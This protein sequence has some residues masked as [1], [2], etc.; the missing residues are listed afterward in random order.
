MDFTVLAATSV[1]DDLIAKCPPAES[2][3]D[4]FVTMSKATIAMVEKTTGFGTASTLSSQPLNVPQSGSS[5]SGK[6]LAERKPLQRRST[7]QPPL[8][9]FDMDL[10][11]LFSEEEI[12]SRPLAQQFAL[13]T[14]NRR[15]QARSTNADQLPSMPGAPQYQSQHLS[16]SGMSTMQQ[17]QS[18]PALYNTTSGS[19]QP[20]HQHTH[21]QSHTHATY[22]AAYPPQSSTSPILSTTPQ[23]QHQHQ[24]YA[25]LTQTISQTTQSQ[26][27]PDLGGFDFDFLDTFPPPDFTGQG[28]G[29]GGWEDFDMNF[30]TGGMGAVGWGES[31]GQWDGG[32]GGGV[33]MFDGFF[34]GEVGNGGA[35]GNGNGGGGGG[36]FG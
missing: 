26:S 14:A 27:N 16:H 21:S 4:A 7:N 13:H 28:G 25:P 22:N 17:Q 18:P 19:S 29:G 30:A 2:C 36:G 8:P 31:G 34:F 24:Q 23:H 12:A 35:N 32:M 15:A 33:D 11:E 1:L 20:P 6:D 3:R 10:R 5:S 9:Q